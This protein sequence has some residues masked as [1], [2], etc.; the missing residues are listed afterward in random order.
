MDGF[1]AF[2]E[3]YEMAVGGLFTAFTRLLVDGRAVGVHVAMTADRPSGVPT[4]IAAAFPQRVVLRQSDE[5]AYS[6]L[7]VPKDVLSPLSPPG[8]AMQVE[9]PQE[10]QL[11]ILGDDVATAEQARMV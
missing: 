11:A 9:R 8:R 7:A 6:M 2:R 5:E 1:G 4:S 10:L 3:Q